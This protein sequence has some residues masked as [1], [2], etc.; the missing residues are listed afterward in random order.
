[1]F[2]SR[3]VAKALAEVISVYLKDVE[4]ENLAAPAHKR[5]LRS[6]KMQVFLKYG[7]IRG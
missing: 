6:K 5:L 7:A 3:A 1:M 4:D 2:R